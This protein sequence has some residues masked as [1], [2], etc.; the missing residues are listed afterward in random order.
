VAAFDFVIRRNASN[1]DSYP[2]AAS[3][4]LLD[5]DTAVDNE[6]SGITHSA[7]TFTLGETGHFLIM[8]SDIAS[9]TQTNRI[10]GKLTITLA[11]TEIRAG[12]A[13]FWRRGANSHNGCVA[14]V[15][16]IINVTTTTGNGDEL[17]I[18]AERSDN[19]SPTPAYA[20]VAGDR[21]GITILKLD[22][23]QNF[24]R[25]EGSSFNG[26]TSD[27]VRVVADLD[28][29]LEQDSPFTRTGNVIDIAT[30]NRVLCIYTMQFVETT[31][32][33]GRHEYQSDLELA[34][35]RVIGSLAMHYIRYDQDTDWECRSLMVML[36]PSS[37][38]DLDLGI[39]TRELGEA[40]GWLASLQLWELPSGA[41]TASME[42]TG[43]DYNTADTEFTFD[44]LPQID[45]AAFT[46][47]AG[48]SNIDVDNAG[49]Y[50]V[51]AAQGL[52]TL[53][54]GAERRAPGIQFKVNTTINDQA[55]VST[56]NR[57]SA[58]SAC[59]MLGNLS[60]NDSIRVNNDR[61]SA[62]TTALQIDVGRF[63]VIRLSSLAAAA[64]GGRIMS[65]LAG[66]GGL[67][68]E[69]GIAGAGGGLAG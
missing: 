28:T 49:D 56:Y 30:N 10:G 17:Q 5:W 11:G 2:N 43:G 47:T 38:Q 58:D 35:T 33:T 8:A 37:G 52:D 61:L 21:S 51:I 7:G 59:T 32:G 14:S 27:G 45:T 24:A 31:G 66:A 34:G 46:A 6:G 26:S 68:A 54:V 22:D 19:Q 44:T 12:Y 4:L 23:T 69:G 40:K 60:A 9:S 1:T 29:T 36:E 16:A 20:R 42:A 50:I 41:E 57:G 25:Y 65:S 67:A 63:T 15:V 39:I 48:N 13:S 53:D 55:G 64:P 3:D 62:V 18:R